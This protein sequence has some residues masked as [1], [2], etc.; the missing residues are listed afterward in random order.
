MTRRGRIVGLTILVVIAALALLFPAHTP[1]LRGWVVSRNLLKQIELPD[2]GARQ[3]AAWSAIQ[4]PSDTLENA[5]TRGL[6]GHEPDANVREAYAYAL[7]MIG[8]P[9]NIAALEHVVDNDPSGLVR[10]S[11]WL[12]AA[13]VDPEHMLTLATTHI[14]T[15]DS[16][17]RL[18]IAQARLSLGDAQD[19]PVLLVQAHS[20]DESRRYVACR[21]LQ[22]WLMPALDAIGRWP[23]EYQPAKELP[24]PTEWI[25]EIERRCASENVEQLVADTH[26]RM[27]EAEQVRR[28]IA[29]INGARRELIQLL[30]G[31][32]TPEDR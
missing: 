21:A 6:F 22:K 20:R 24:W 23:L 13:R 28:D 18:G 31:P 25:D 4:Y 7:G 3:R 1:G 8:D 2:P 12:A 32:T 29:R 14:E 16:W 10:C 11:A 30:I 27:R 19:L 9:R 15:Q 17:D 26:Q 5:M